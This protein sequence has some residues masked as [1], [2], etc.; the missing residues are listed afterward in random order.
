[1]EVGLSAAFTLP[2]RVYYEDTDAGGVVYHANYLRFMERARSEWLSHLK[3]EHGP[4]A[5]EHDTLFVV[6]AAQIEYLRPA[7]LSDLLQV[8]VAIRQIRRSAIVFAQ[9]IRCGEHLLV[10]G[11]ITVVAVSASRFRPCAVPPPVLAALQPWL[12]PA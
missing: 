6:R 12:P 1:M 9:H 7:R 8:E 2:V 4:L 5:A 10:T 11:E 3:L